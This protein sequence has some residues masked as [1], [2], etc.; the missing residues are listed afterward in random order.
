MFVSASLPQTA[1]MSDAEHQ[2]TDLTE[3]DAARY[4]GYRPITLRARRMQGRGPAY[5][6][7]GRSI[8][9]TLT[10]LDARRAA[11]RVATRDSRNPL[12]AA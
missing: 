7:A 10:D 3:R 1:V 6:R 9:Y 12:E 8:R 11:H 2:S 4:I 5:I